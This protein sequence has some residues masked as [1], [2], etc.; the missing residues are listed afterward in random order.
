MTQG[1]DGSGASSAGVAAAAK[2]MASP[3]DVV[4]RAEHSA[5]EF[6]LAVAEATIQALQAKVAQLDNSAVSPASDTNATA[7]VKVPTGG[8]GLGKSPSGSTGLTPGAGAANAVSPLSAPGSATASGSGSS[9]PSS[10]ASGSVART[11]PAP[12]EDAESS[13]AALT[14]QVAALSTSVAQLQRLQ[15]QNLVSPINAHPGAMHQ[16]MR[17]PPPPPLDTSLGSLPRM[18][19]SAHSVTSPFPQQGFLAAGGTPGP[20][21]PISR[22]FSGP[23]SDDKWGAAGQ[24]NRGGG[25]GAGGGGG[26]GGQWNSQG[27]A[28]QT[29]GISSMNNVGSGAAAPGAGIV[30]TKWEHL[31]LKVDLLRSISKY[32]YVSRGRV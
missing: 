8:R 3:D 7:A 10:S 14:Q 25:G 27:S 6:R 26:G 12:A 21:T 4:S 16:Q 32:G 23:M 1:R 17:M 24:G 30:V 15:T 31:N 22:P 19:H 11:P 29:N 28:V 18:P 13:I 9:I 2:S 20:R 5:L